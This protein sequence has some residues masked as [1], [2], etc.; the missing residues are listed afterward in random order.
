MQPVD[1]GLLVGSAV[2]S[3]TLMWLLCYRVLPL[4]NAAGFV[5]LSYA[6]FVFMAWLATRQ[7]HGRLLAKDRLMSI[8]ITT[9]ALAFLVPLGWI[10]GTVIWRGIA[11]LDWGFLTE[12][13]EFAGPNDRADVGGAYHA[14]WGTMQQVLIAVAICVPLGVTTAVF[15]N[16]VGGR[17]AR[18]V[19]FVVDAMSGVP[20]IVAGLF[21]FAVYILG[22]GRDFSGFAA[23]LAL[24]VL[25]LPTITRTTEE[26]LRLVPGGLREAS[27]ALGATEWKTTWSVVLPTARTGVI[28]A[29]ILGVARAVGETALLI[30]TAF[31]NDVLNRNPFN[32]PQESLPL[33]VYNLIRAPK[34]AQIARAWT[35]ALVLVLIVLVL[36]TIA[37]VLGGRSVGSGGSRRGRRS[38]QTMPADEELPLFS[39]QLPRTLEPEPPP[40][41]RTSGAT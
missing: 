26:V 17:L 29:A 5:A 16:E 27:L 22:L 41:L 15:L 32:G 6:G 18:P 21:I 11:L 36:F 25:M 28:T 8:L 12:T 38:D 33:Y 23:A 9:G 24:S 37:R 13:M 34:E 7:T 2:S 10:L 1:Y 19:R 39:S 20:S 31:G 4:G 14:I 3:T 35:G 30:M 40:D